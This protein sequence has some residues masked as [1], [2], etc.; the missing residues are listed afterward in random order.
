VSARRKAR[1]DAIV[2]VPANGSPPAELYD[3]DAAVWR[4]HD[5]YVAF[6]QAHGWED[7][8][9]PQDRLWRVQLETVH[10]AVR[11]NHAANAWGR[12]DGITDW[13]RLRALGLIDS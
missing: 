10:P 8:L 4:D 12:A 3:S 5:L 1:A 11:R 6:M 7:G 13:H 9:P 2:S